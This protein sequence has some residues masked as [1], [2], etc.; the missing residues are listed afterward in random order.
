M[1]Q[2]NTT[3]KYPNISVKLLGE[4]GN[5]FNLIGK[6]SQALKAA[7]IPSQEIRDFQT[8]VTSGT[9]NDAIA[10]ITRW[11]NVE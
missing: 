6:T 2:N 4:D 8:E 5:V 7:G 11:V 9:Y 3:V 10:T 1:I